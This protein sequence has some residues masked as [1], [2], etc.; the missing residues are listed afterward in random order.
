MARKALAAGLMAN[1]DR[2][3]AAQA[4][5]CRKDGK[6]FRNATADNVRH[7]MNRRAARESRDEYRTTTLD[8]AAGDL[9]VPADEEKRVHLLDPGNGKRPD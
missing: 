8:S 4:K 2:G 5:E 7:C 3:G 6:V 1:L 9:P